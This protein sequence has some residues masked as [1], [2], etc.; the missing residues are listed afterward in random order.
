MRLIGLLFWVFWLAV[1]TLFYGVPDCYAFEIGIC[2]KGGIKSFYHSHLNNRIMQMLK[3]IDARYI[4]DSY[5]WSW[6]EHSKGKFEIDNDFLN[7]ISALNSNNI[8]PILAL[9][10]G[11][12]LYASDNNAGP[13]TK[14]QIEAFA[15]YVSYLVSALKGKVYAWEIWNEPDLKNVWL[16]QPDIKQYTDLVK[17]VAPIIKKLDPQ[18]LVVA[19]STS[20]P[21]GKFLYGLN[22][23]E[24]L[25]NIDV[26]SFHWYNLSAPD[27]V[28]KNLSP[29]EFF[30]GKVKQFGKIAWITEMG[31]PTSL[32]SEGVTE[33]QQAEFLT[34][35]LKLAQKMG[36]DLCIIYDL[37][38]DGP[39]PRNREH[40]FGLFHADD[41]PKPVVDRL[42]AL[43]LQP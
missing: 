25:A 15:R 29:V 41:T 43:Q 34:R 7:Y 38:D 8:K 24:I 20:T 17:E 1:T 39:D 37:Q 40:R 27:K 36:V 35:D 32:D 12:K 10:Y 9:C 4:R 18:A 19:G 11:N 42:K 23:P 26:I 6:V 3:T 31:Y 16:P 14:E 30:I 28:D 21:D 33:A 2:T 5:E 13:N 22:Q